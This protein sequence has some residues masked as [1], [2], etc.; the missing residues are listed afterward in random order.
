MMIND[1]RALA[2]GLGAL[3]ATLAVIATFL[4]W[5]SFDVVAPAGPF[6][7]TFAVPITLWGLTTIAPVLILVGAVVAL[8]CIAMI[9]S[10]VSGIV[11]ALVGLGITAYAAVRCFDIPNLGVHLANASPGIKAATVLESGP[12]LS[13]GAGLMLLM[14]S[15][16]D[17]LPSRAYG[18]EA[19]A[20]AEGGV[21]FQGATR[22]PEGAPTPRSTRVR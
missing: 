7:R 11:E 22:R 4:P 21:P 17:L 1:S 13:I 14:G 20:P 2:R 16:G 9:D 6:V 15:L 19:E 12:I 8:V 3:G 18:Y 10:R 5:Y